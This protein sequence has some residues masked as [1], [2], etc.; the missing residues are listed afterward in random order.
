MVYDTANAAANADSYAVEMA[1]MNCRL[2]DLKSEL[3]SW[4]MELTQ[5]E[6]HSEHA[7]C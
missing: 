4:D 5:H 2:I 7:H 3:F 6:S 1:C